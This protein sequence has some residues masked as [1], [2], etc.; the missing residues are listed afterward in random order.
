MMVRVSDTSS[1]RSYAFGQWILQD[2][3]L[4]DAAGRAVH[5]PPK[6]LAVLSLL[7]D[8]NGALI[9]KDVLLDNVWPDCDVAEESLTRCIYSLRKLLGDNKDYIVTV[10]GKG[11]RFNCPAVQ[12]QG[13][14]RGP[15]APSLVI[16]PFRGAEAALSLKVHDQLTRRLTQ[17]FAEALRVMPASLTAS[18]RE[19]ADTLSIVERLAPDYYLGGFCTATGDHWELS[20]EL[21][22]A[23]GHVLIHS[24]ALSFTDIAEAAQ[25]IAAI[26]TQRLPGLRSVS[27]SCSSYPLALAYLNG[28]LGLQTYTAQSVEQARQQ[29]LQCVQLDPSYAP[30][31]GGLAES[32]LALSSLGAVSESKAFEQAQ[33]ALG[34]AL[35]IEPDNHAALV[36]LA[37]LTSL[38]GS[39][40]AA[41]AL[42]RRALLGADCADAYYHYA[43]H[44]WAM[45]RHA[46]AM[47]SIQTC[48]SLNPDSVAARLLRI[49]IAECVDRQLALDFVTQALNDD[50]VGHPVLLA[51]LAS[52][53]GPAA[54]P[55]QPSASACAIFTRTSPDHTP[56]GEVARLSLYWP[57]RADL[58][59]GADDA[60]VAGAARACDEYPGAGRY[61][62]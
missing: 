9:S 13:A 17:A 34:K 39:G 46:P 41:E 20:L 48:L 32:W 55:A 60:K 43:W 26:I 49:R 10:Y 33:H 22:R 6:E 53:S 42:F 58:G 14:Q 40:D 19:L 36:R 54:R 57:C 28:L 62:A 18:V 61:P 45:G 12:L 59:H 38:Q 4:Q 37:L 27:E 2:E 21:V 31:W 29:F 44:Q 1:M 35:S 16:L 24:Q 52:L 5:L 47:K 8:A 7:L 25:L 3:V 30:P 56:C 15:A 50:A 23:K 51:M 11:Y